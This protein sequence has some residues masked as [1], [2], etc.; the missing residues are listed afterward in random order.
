MYVGAGLPRTGTLSMKSALTIL[1]KGKCYHMAEAFSGNQDH[2]DIWMNGIKNKNTPDQW[3]QFFKTEGYI[4][5]VDFPFALFWKELS[6]VYPDA[7]IVLTT[8]DSEKWYDSV[9]NSIWIFHD[10]MRNSWTFK[11]TLSLLDGRKGAGDWIHHME[12]TKGYGMNQNLY[13][14][15]TG[16]PE[17]AAKFFRDWDSVVKSSIPP[18]RLLVH[19]AKEG[20]GPLCK[21]LDLPIPDQPYPNLNDAASIRKTV[22]MLSLLNYGLFYLLPACIAVGATYMFTMK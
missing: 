7:K 19:S 3:K 15:I 13:D 17:N 4:A 11:K 9:K 16:G 8:R 10:K 1:L 14:A 22:Q 20:W 21:F 5:G 6:G 12:N 18:E 2:M